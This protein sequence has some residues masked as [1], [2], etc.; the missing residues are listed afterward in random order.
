MLKL[1]DYIVMGGGIAIAAFLLINMG[2]D[3]IRQNRG[4]EPK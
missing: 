1:L 2:R 4:D 3:M